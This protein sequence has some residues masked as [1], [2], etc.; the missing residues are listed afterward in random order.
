MHA[1]ITQGYFAAFYFAINAGSL[2]S[3]LLTPKLRADVSCFDQDECFPLA[4]GVPAGLMAIATVIFVIGRR[5]Y[6]IR[7]PK[8]NVVL[9]VLRATWMGAATKFRNWRSGAV[10]RH[11]SWLDPAAKRFGEGFVR[12]IRQLSS[13]LF[14]F[15]PLPVFWALYDQQGSRWTLQATQ[16]KG[17]SMGPLGRFRPDQMQAVNSIFVL[18][19][20]P[21]FEKLLYPVLAKL[22]IPPSPL[23]VRKERVCTLICVLVTCGGC[24]AY[25]F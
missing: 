6:T 22:R 20:I 8:T 1:C 21:V 18:M 19:F 17:F 9:D 10:H 23:Q 13:I 5:Y 7:I 2:I 11:G 4:F 15:L 12:D 16:M 25:P 3:T 24:G 14:L